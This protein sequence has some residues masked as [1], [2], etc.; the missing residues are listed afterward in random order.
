MKHFIGKQ[1]IEVTLRQKAGAFEWQQQLSRRFREDIAPALEELFDRMADESTYLRLNKLEIDLGVITENDIKSGDWVKKIIAQMETALL[2]AVQK[3]EPGTLKSTPGMR[4]FDLWLHFLQHGYLPRFTAAPPADWS[5]KIL[6]TLGLE[7]SAAAQLK[8]LLA[9]SPRALDR[10]VLQYPDQ[11]LVHL[12]E[13]FTG[14]NQQDLANALQEIR[15][16]WKKWSARRLSA[17]NVQEILPL[18]QIMF[19]AHFGSHSAPG[20]EDLKS[21]LKKKAPQ[22]QRELEITFWRKTLHFVF[23]KSLRAAPK[24]YLTML[25]RE[26]PGFKAMVPLWQS[27][28]SQVTPVAPVLQPILQDLAKALTTIKGTINPS[29]LPDSAG[30]SKS[31][32]AEKADAT[33]TA[34]SAATQEGR[35][36]ETAGLVLLHPFLS[37]FFRKR[38]LLEAEGSAF[39][40]DWSRQK[41]VHLLHFLACGEEAPAEHQLSL[42]K[43]LCGIPFQQ[44]V[45]G[46]LLLS[47]EDKSEANNLLQAV[48]AHWGALGNTSPDGLRE[49]FLIREGKLL[50]QNDNWQLQVENKTIDILLSKLP[51]GFGLVKTPWMKEMLF[52]EWN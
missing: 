10:L 29:K 37:P 38:G 22:S 13:L 51:W 20:A 21:F 32:N 34:D 18:L 24:N 47:A 2:R 52:V 44:P 27:K 28:A 26:E 9:Q 45:D 49:G 48:V 16:F 25:F 1:T 50:Q 11:F 12:V 42:A 19:P 8:Q 36:I 30:D 5:K 39:L 40:D 33:R 43:L 23:E 31:L 7:A 46:A 41:A 14:Q 4:S 35:H 3:S 17:K 15:V 6:E